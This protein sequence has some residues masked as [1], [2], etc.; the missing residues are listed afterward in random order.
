MTQVQ[1]T[2]QVIQNTQELQSAAEALETHEKVFTV[3]RVAD[4][5]SRIQDCYIV[6]NFTN[7][8]S[9]K[10]EVNEILSRFGLKSP[11]TDI[12]MGAIPAAYA[13]P[14]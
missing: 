3:S 6:V 9:S 5:M 8:V 7:D 1:V 2:P 14:I 10:E 11:M 4:D 13:Y 12:E